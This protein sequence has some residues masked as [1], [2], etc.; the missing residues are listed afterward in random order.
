[1]SGFG[2]KNDFVEPSLQ[3]QII[4]QTAQAAHGGVSVGVDQPGRCHMALQAHLP[5]PVEFSLELI[6]RPDGRH[7]A[8][9]D[10]DGAG[11][12]ALH[13]IVAGHDPVNIGQKPV[14]LAAANR[15]S[16]GE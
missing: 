3:R 4:G 10:G 12:D 9:F 16:W 14:H 15:I 6:R 2:R 13:G 5:P 7:A 8:T 1:V 11:L